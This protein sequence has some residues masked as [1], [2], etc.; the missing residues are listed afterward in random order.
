MM[1]HESLRVIGLN[2]IVTGMPYAIHAAKNQLEVALITEQKM[3]I[4]VS[5]PS[6]IKTVPLFI[7]HQ[8]NRIY[9][10]YPNP[11]SFLVRLSRPSVGG[12]H[13]S[14]I[15][16]KSNKSSNLENTFKVKHLF[17]NISL[18][19]KHSLHMHTYC[20]HAAS[21]NAQMQRLELNQETTFGHE[22]VQN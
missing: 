19:R 21:K 15:P 4:I 1:F 6:C 5:I 3:S 17:G 20:M 2:S 13:A 11:I 16:F 10:I 7:I 14:I 18:A 12:W 9:L 8:I 22:S